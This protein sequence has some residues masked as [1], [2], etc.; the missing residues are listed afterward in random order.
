MAAEASHRSIDVIVGT[1]V[2]FLARTRV[3]GIAAGC[4]GLR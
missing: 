1:H 3:D 4:E 2:E